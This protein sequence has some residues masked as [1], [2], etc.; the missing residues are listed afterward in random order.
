M[1]SS[2]HWSGFVIGAVPRVTQASPMGENESV[3]LS[4][5]VEAMEEAGYVKCSLCL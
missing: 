2:G 4:F 5:L 1:G 3:S